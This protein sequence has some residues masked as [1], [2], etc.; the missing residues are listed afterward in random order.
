MRVSAINEIIFNNSQ[1][2]KPEVSNHQADHGNLEDIP[3]PRLPKRV[4]LWKRVWYVLKYEDD[5]SNTEQEHSL[6]PVI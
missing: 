4:S 5:E 6:N 1:P 2:I 3:E